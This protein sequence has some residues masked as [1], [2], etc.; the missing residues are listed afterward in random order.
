MDAT[1]W[2]ENETTAVAAATE[3]T[4]GIYFQS[5]KGY[6]EGSGLSG[7]TEFNLWGFYNADTGDCRDFANFFQVLCDS[8]G[9]EGKS[10]AIGGTFTTKEILLIGLGPSDWEEKDFANHGIGWYNN[11]YDAMLKLNKDSP[12][13]ATNLTLATYKGYLYKSGTWNDTQ[14]PWNLT[15]VDYQ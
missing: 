2:A 12:L 6:S 14:T 4:H 5:Y 11:V 13:I 3:I 10:K 9:I 7:N 15:R 1:T 8:I